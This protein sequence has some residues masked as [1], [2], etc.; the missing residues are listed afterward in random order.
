MYIFLVFEGGYVVGFSW[1][2]SET[3]TGG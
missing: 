2:I 1:S 3:F